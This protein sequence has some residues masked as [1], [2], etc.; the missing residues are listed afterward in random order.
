MFLG[1]YLPTPE[2][3]IIS[4]KYNKPR[5]MKPKK[6]RC[7]YRTVTLQIPGGLNRTF[8]IHRLVY[9]FWKERIPKGMQINHID[10]NKTNNNL[11]NLELVSRKDNM[12]HAQEMGLLVVGEDSYLSKLK[13]SQ[14]IEI[15][16]SEK[17]TKILSE[18]Y[19]ILQKQIR[20]IK[21]GKS[22]K[23]VYEKFK[24]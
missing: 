10:G 17:D 9:E 4:F 16:K 3:Y 22:W 14:V 19:N 13:E 7:G 6:H 21:N 8:Y 12:K 1:Y 5:V 2:G 11:N 15:L 23:H 18:N 20:N 24:R